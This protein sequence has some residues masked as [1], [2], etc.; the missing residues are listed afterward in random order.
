MVRRTIGSTMWIMVA[1][2]GCA[3]E[4]AEPITDETTQTSAPDESRA[5]EGA[6]GESEAEGDADH[7]VEHG[8]LGES[9]GALT[10]PGFA[11]LSEQSG[12]AL[13]ST[14]ISAGTLVTQTRLV[15]TKGTPNQRWVSSN[16]NFSPESNQGLCLQPESTAASARLRLQKC[17][18]SALQGWKLQLVPQNGVNLTRW[19]N[20]A[21]GFLLDN[22][23]TNSEGAAVTVRPFSSAASQK[24]RRVF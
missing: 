9:Q 17:N 16:L 24:W 11:L 8:A 6:P 3:D 21:T 13:T 5:E 10:V 1:L 12:K 7:G 2:A 23:G 20:L 18:G 19:T 22:G 14:T 15:G 4:D